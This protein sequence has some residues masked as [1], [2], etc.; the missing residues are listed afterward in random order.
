MAG[1]ATLQM[2][3]CKRYT[4]NVTGNLIEAS[5]KKEAETDSV[6]KSSDECKVQNH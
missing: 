2:L 1:N 5:E 4:A 3:H 6:P